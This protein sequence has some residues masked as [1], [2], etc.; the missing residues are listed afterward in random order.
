MKLHRSALLVAQRC[1]HPSIGNVQYTKQ[2]GTDEDE[3]KDIQTAI[4]CIHIC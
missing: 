1:V 4:F 2:L 3:Y